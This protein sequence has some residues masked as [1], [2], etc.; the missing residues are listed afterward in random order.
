MAHGVLVELVLVMAVSVLVAAAG[1]RRLKIPPVVGFIVA[2]ILIG[3]GG[4]GL[5]SDR[6]Q[7]EVV[8]EVGV[9]LLL[10]TVGLKLKLGDLWS[11]RGSVLGGGGAQVV[12]TGG[13][14]AAAA[15]ALGRP[16]PEALVWGATI[17]LSSTALVLWLL[18][19]SGDLGTA[20]GRTMVSVL[21]FQDLAVVPIMLALPLAAGHATS[22][23]EI[24]GL[25]GRSAG[26]VVLTVVGAR[27]VFPWVTARVV[28]TGSRELFT[29]T[30]VLVAIGTALLFGHFGLSVALGAFLAGMV[31]SES[32]Y[33]GRMIEDLTPLRDVFNS[34]FFVSMGMLVVPSLWVQRP[35]AT[36][37]VALG[38]VVV[39][40][41][42]AGGV[43]FG[44]LRRPGVALAAGLGLAQIGEF[45]FVVAREAHGLGVL[46]TAGL[47][48]FM[49]V[50]VPTMILTPYLLAA[51]HSLARRLEPAQPGPQPVEL[52]DHVVIVGHGING[53][54]V[55]RALGLLEIP[56]V[57]VDLNP[58]TRTEVE[59]AGGQVL[60]GDARSP[61]VLE[62]AGMPRARGLVAA[63]ADAASTREVIAASRA[64]NPG[65]T[66]VARTRYLREVEPLIE[67][68]ADHVVPEE[69][70]TSLELTGRVL[71]LYGAPPWVVEREKVALRAEGYGLLRNGAEPARHPTL[72]A[73]CRLP[74][75]AGV[76]VP[77]DSPVVGRSLADLD[78]RRRTG[79]TVLAVA[80]HGEILTN[81]PPD[82][83]LVPG[84]LLVSLASAGAFEALQW[85]LERDPAKP[86]PQ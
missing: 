15:V 39:K 68:G 34:L 9:M 63:I 29:L 3:P 22:L 27:F 60:E 44:L 58:H 12:I 77:E 55:A 75:V 50:A 59:A 65:A 38:V 36:L 85:M 69:F 10:F 49:S 76:T 47:D 28:A 6:H 41:V 48:L 30:T 25:L 24:A 67:L 45:S 66:L 23:G 2:G 17:A 54:N 86:D 80:R 26:V 72:D 37:L 35:L 46:D 64:L 79:A 20:Q 18:E 81:P 31:V 70:E 13:G 14:V 16:I 74:D 40:A 5:V 53:R 78:L 8:A 61:K 83:Q 43:T 51:G 52:D 4:L 71:E 42:V 57:V 56:F 82:L 62:A 11:L 73:L 32:E 33:V 21:L 7:I 19:S 1:L 84:D